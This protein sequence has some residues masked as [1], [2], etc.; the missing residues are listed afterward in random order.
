MFIRALSVAIVVLVAF[1]S[2]IAAQSGGPLGFVSKL[3][4]DLDV[5]SGARV[6]ADEL[7]ANKVILPAAEGPVA[8]GSTAAQIQLR[9]ATCR[10][11]IHRATPFKS[12]AAY[13]R[14][15]G[16]RGARSRRPR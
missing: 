4:S 3:G 9:G 16:R 7:A 8:G 5:R 10:S 1:N 2:P 11:T 14:S 13:A 15:S 12:S 6:L